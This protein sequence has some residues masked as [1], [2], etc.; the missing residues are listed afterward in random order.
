MNR[1]PLGIHGG[2][3]L[4][5]RG[6]LQSRQ[7][8][9]LLSRE[10]FLADEP[11]I[12]RLAKHFSNPERAVVSY[13]SDAV[14]TSRLVDR[15]SFDRFPRWLRRFLKGAVLLR[16]PRRWRHFFLSHREH[17]ASIP[18][19]AQALRELVHLLGPGKEV[20][21]VTR[22]ASGRLASLIADDVG[23]AKIVC[24]GYPFQ[25][26]KQGPEPARYEHLLALQ[27]PFLIFQGTTDAYGGLDAVNQYQFAPQTKIEWV[28]TNHSFNI[29]E[30]EW[31]RV[32]QRIDEFI[33][34]PSLATLSTH[35]ASERCETP[36]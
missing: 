9:V 24:L 1:I 8:L 32:L 6:S 34:A 10:N 29:S 3:E 11:L 19:R 27:T 36:R 31:Q 14:M 33:S 16:Y 2:G 4:E 13:R 17:V 18:F 20:V 35:P 7:I 23:L 5:V 15:P 30:S 28:K 22:S 25:H 12:A 26:P 21:F